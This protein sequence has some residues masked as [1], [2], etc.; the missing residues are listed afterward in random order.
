[1]AGTIRERACSRSPVRS[2][3]RMADADGC[4]S[5]RASP[6]W[7]A[8]CRVTVRGRMAEPCRS[9]LLQYSTPRVLL[10]LASSAASS[11]DT[12]TAAA[13]CR[14]VG[15]LTPRD[16][17]RRRCSVSSSE[18]RA[19]AR[20]VR[21]A[22]SPHS[23][24][25]ARWVTRP[26]AI[27]AWTPPSANRSAEDTAQGRGSSST[28]SAPLSTAA[29]ARAWRRTNAKSP[30]WTKFPLMTQTT[31]VSGPSRR[32]TSSIRWTWPL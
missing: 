15:K 22:P 3:A 13:L 5:S 11:G 32:R 16:S 26:V 25:K 17:S 1:M 30:R 7:A 10:G 9:R 8:P 12:S 28:R 14:A 27:R 6:S 2:R 31:A 4:S 20:R 19:A 18:S 29:F 21:A 23:L 24:P